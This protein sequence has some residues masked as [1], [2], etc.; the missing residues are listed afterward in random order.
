M[1]SSRRIAVASSR[2]TTGLRM[3]PQVGLEILMPTPN[4][5]LPKRASQEH[6]LEMAQESRSLAS[7]RFLC[8]G[9]GGKEVRR[10]FTFD[11]RERSSRRAVFVGTTN[12]GSRSGSR[13]DSHLSPTVCSIHLA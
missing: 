4:G 13:R 9:R 2:T 12:M 1:C 11:R 3:T 6:H 5:R 8:S 7:I 10:W